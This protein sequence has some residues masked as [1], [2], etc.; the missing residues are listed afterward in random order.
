MGT[1]IKMFLEFLQQS[2]QWIADAYHQ[3]SDEE[4][5][6]FL[7][8]GLPAVSRDHDLF[9]TL[10]SVRGKGLEPKGLPADVSPHVKAI[11]AMNTYNLD[12]SYCSIDT[13]EKAYLTSQMHVGGVG[14]LQMGSFSY[15]R[16]DIER[17]KASSDYD[18]PFSEYSPPYISICVYARKMVA[19]RGYKDA[20]VVFWFD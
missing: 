2:G 1:D 20:R 7:D 5:K 6:G 8:S 18:N 11:E 16:Y 19:E 13:L 12:H 17:D 10:A 9:A 14:E 3:K 15:Y 4:A